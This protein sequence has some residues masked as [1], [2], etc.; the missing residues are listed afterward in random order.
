MPARMPADTVAGMTAST[1]DEAS[2]VPGPSA[3]ILAQVADA[4]AWPLL[5]LRRDG[6]LLHANLAARR[7]LQSGAPLELSPWQHVLPSAVSRRA[8]F[9]AAL[10]ASASTLARGMLHWTEARSS[11]TAT[12]AP[13]E[14]MDTLDPPL[15]LAL[16]AGGR[17]ADIDAFATL[18][19]LTAAET[20]VL[21]RLAL[22]ESSARAASALGVAKATVRSQ[23]VSMRHKTHHAS[24][25]ELLRA[26][27]GMP[28]LPPPAA[29]AP[30]RER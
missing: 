10:E 3:E 29:P 2:P 27:A 4:L 1:H 24:V 6:T 11:L 5:L 19:G 22:G 17:G 8:E 16:S 21:H 9:A 15:L 14:A 26:L 23:I 30:D 28:P 7:L 18:H 20:R 25:G 12:L 13:L